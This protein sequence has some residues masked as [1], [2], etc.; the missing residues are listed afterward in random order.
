MTPYP[1][2]LHNV[3][4]AESSKSGA[5][6]W[7]FLLISGRR[8][9]LPLTVAGSAKWLFLFLAV[10]YVAAPV[11]NFIFFEV[12][13]LIQTLRRLGVLATLRLCGGIAVFGVKTVIHI[14]PEVI[15]AMKPR[16]STK[17]YTTRKPFR[18]VI[19]TGSQVIWSGVIVPV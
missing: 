2:E 17:K 14:A 16:A 12:G 9:D 18:A 10:A 13:N 19:A 1:S 15:R 7:S 6:V 11:P 5:I 4:L 8:G 3:L